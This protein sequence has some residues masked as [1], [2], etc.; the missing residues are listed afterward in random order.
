[1]LFISLGR[2]GIELL[3]DHTRGS[4]DSPLREEADQMCVLLAGHLSRPCPCPTI[5][6][7][8]PDGL[9]HSLICGKTQTL[10]PICITALALDQSPPDIGHYLRLSAFFSSGSI[11]VFDINHNHPSR[12][13]QKFTYAPFLPNSRTT[14]II[15]AVYHHLLL[16][17]LSQAFHLSIYD[18][19]CG[20]I[21]H[22][23]T[24]SSFTSFPPNSPV[25]STP[26]PSTYK[27]VLAYAIPVYSAHW[28]VGAMEL[29]I[30]ADIPA[31][32][33]HDID[34]DVDASRDAERPSTVGPS[35]A[36]I[37][38]KTTR[39]YDAPNGWIDDRKLKLM[40][41]QWGRKVFGVADTHT[42]GKWVVL[43]PAT[44][45]E[46]TSSSSS[47]PSPGSLSPFGSGFASSDMHSPNTLQP[48]RLLMPTT[49]SAA[50]TGSTPKLVFV[51]NLLGPL[52]AVSSL[53][54]SDGR[55]VGLAANG[56]V[57]VW[58]LENGSGV[59]VAG[60]SMTR[61]LKENLTSMVSTSLLFIPMSTDHVRVT[62]LISHSSGMT[63]PASFTPELFKYVFTKFLPEVVVHVCGQE[64]ARPVTIMTVC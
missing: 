25:R 27:L 30:S 19:S 34:A 28:S 46:P 26:S 55:C 1:M 42:D 20:S 62:C 17:T 14:P 41:E 49:A 21:S 15:Q 16:I 35:M 63:R 47:S 7:R 8:S 32:G 12:S 51:W 56:S 23:Q 6:L 48:Y 58:D 57:W 13:T 64:Q 59:E 9:M 61:F 53:S 24:L 11:T 29:V 10:D 45:H 38:T 37:T 60:A 18:L 4:L 2:C 54:L 43:A 33:G 50:A 31:S 5:R 52:G 22:R 3:D 39:T 44:A 40:R 36:V